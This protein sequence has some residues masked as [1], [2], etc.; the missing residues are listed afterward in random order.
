MR[1]ISIRVEP[2]ARIFAGAYAFFGLLAFFLYAV[3]K[4][5]SLTL[6]F[7]V[8]APIVQLSLNLHLA[9]SNGVAYNIFLCVAAV[10]CYAFSGWVTGLALALCF[11]VIAKQTGGIDAKFVITRTEDA[12]ASQV[13]TLIN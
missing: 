8:L 10:V 7:G 3:A 5:G 9:A 11:N 6:P 12:P 13:S 1:I 4:T 2:V